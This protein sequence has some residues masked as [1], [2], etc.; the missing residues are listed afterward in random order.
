MTMEP[1]TREAPDA[2]TTVGL[3]LGTTVPLAAV[4]EVAVTTTGVLL[5]VVMVLL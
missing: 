2:V 3:E 1:P 4:Y 5:M